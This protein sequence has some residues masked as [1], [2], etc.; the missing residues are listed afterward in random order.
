MTVF[1]KEQSDWSNPTTSLRGAKQRSSL[2]VITSHLFVTASPDCRVSTEIPVFQ[3]FLGN[4]V[5]RYS[6]SCIPALVA[7]TA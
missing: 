3:Y 1:A 4:C 6:T 5:L 2:P 7:M